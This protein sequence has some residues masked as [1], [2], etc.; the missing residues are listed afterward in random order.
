MKES[1]NK[2]I[3]GK[4]YTFGQFGAEQ[5]IKVLVRLIKLGGPSFAKILSSGKEGVNLLEQNTEDMD[6][7]SA[8]MEFCSRLEEDLVVS[9]I[10]EFMTQVIYKAKNNEEGGPVIN[11]F[12][13]HFSGNI[14]HM[15]KVF[16][17]ALG[18]QYSDFFDAIGG[19]QG[20]LQKIIK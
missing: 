13:A 5:S 11:I 3:D 14:F 2:T 19:V 12:D 7:S 9:T 8:I 10:K 4:D 17:A 20:F 18:V 16:S 1:V 6:I 15:F